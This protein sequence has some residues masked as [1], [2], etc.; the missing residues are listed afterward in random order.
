MLSALLL[1]GLLP[2]AVLP[3][4]PAGE[5]AVGNDDQDDADTVTAETDAGETGELLQCM[6]GEE[7]GALHQFDASMGST[8]I[9]GF[10]PGTDLVEVDLTNVS[11]DIY[12]D[13]YEQGESS[14]FSV[15]SGP[16]QVATVNFPDLETV[17]QGDVFLRL[18][19]PE[20]G[21]AYQV[22]LAEAIED[23]SA[24]APQTEV[25]QPA[26][27]L[28]PLDPNEPD[29]P[30]PYSPLEPEWLNPDPPEDP[31]SPGPEA[32]SVVDPVDPDEGDDPGPEVD[33]D[34]LVLTPEDPDSPDGPGPFVPE[35]DPTISDPLDPTDPDLPGPGD[36]VILDPELRYSAEEIGPVPQEPSEK[37]GGPAMKPAAEDGSL[38]PLAPDNAPSEEGPDEVAGLPTED[39]Q[40]T[41]DTRTG[42]DLPRALDQ[43]SQPDT[44]DAQAETA[45]E[46]GTETQTDAKPTSDGPDQTVD[47]E[48]HDRVDDENTGDALQ[49]TEP[50][51]QAP[52]APLG[53]ASAGGWFQA[54]ADGAG[55]PAGEIADDSPEDLGEED[56]DAEMLA[57]PETEDPGAV[58]VPD[59]PEPDPAEVDGFRV[60][61]DVLHLMLDPHP[62]PD[63]A[64]LVGPSEDGMDSLVTLDGRILAILRGAPGAS[65]ADL[66][67]E[68]PRAS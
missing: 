10:S 22:S 35:E 15:T 11:E 60:G 48:T 40:A 63:A 7:G 19:D 28:G 21:S 59:P 8:D 20:D 62:G 55:A 44:R 29:P 46:D 4:V 17:P 16:D 68:P 51:V 31:E 3:F 47:A 36:P 13:L 41:G 9:T 43:D 5:E 34:D 66:Y 65:I 54:A 32:P 67:L 53:G 39:D 18:S 58:P 14:S 30:G 37:T 33:P 23:A 56:S 24:T 6:L 2:L 27:A 52:A 64:I 26:E 45:P 49:A 25:E 38:G 57:E 12:F 42:A 61:E 1:A 50:A